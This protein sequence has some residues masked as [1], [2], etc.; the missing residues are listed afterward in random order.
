MVNM[1]SDKSFRLLVAEVKLDFIRKG[2]KPPSTEK[3][4]RIIALRI[5]KEEIIQHEKFI[6][7]K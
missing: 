1:R 3:I 2:R 6:P 5:K 4:T 7:F